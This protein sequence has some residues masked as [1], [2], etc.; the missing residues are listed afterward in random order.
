[1]P[2]PLQDC[3]DEIDVRW[4]AVR[5]RLD[6]IGYWFGKLGDSILAENW[7]NAHSN[8][9]TLHI[10]TDFLAEQMG[11]GIFSVRYW[12]NAALQYVNDYVPWSA[13]DLTM[14]ALL[15]TML[16]ANP[17]QVM[18]FIGLLDAYRQ[19]VWNR[20]F[21]REFFTGLAKGFQQW[22]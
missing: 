13:G 5:S 12:H 1:M 6:S 3:I 4:D 10:H 7:S 21:N 16:S 15:S 11:D 20:P 19:S 8:C 22:P 9:N 14:D 17:N 2:A 18:Y